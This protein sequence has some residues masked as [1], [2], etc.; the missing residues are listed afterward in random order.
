MGSQNSYSCTLS[1]NSARIGFQ[2]CYCYLWFLNVENKLLVLSLPFYTKF[3][4]VHSPFSLLFVDK[5]TGPKH[6][7]IFNNKFII[8][9]SP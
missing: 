2:L 4:A 6:F 3:L 8:N 9:E 1:L 7:E 5:Q